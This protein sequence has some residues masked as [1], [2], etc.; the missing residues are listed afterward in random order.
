VSKVHPLLRRATLG[1]QR[2][3]EAFC[4]K[5]LGDEDDKVRGLAAKLQAKLL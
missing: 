2:L 3:L 5:C 4:G 1:Q